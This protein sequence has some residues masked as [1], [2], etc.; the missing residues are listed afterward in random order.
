MAG[1]TNLQDQLDQL[2]NENFTLN[3]Q[4]QDLRT[5]QG[6]MME[7]YRQE[8]DEAIKVYYKIRQK[9]EMIKNILMMFRKFLNLYNSQQDIPD[10][11]FN[12]YSD[13]CN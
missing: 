1:V 9:H 10:S 3:K 2:Q 8:K 7:T 12:D 6:D 4:I 11:Q 13:F 5:E